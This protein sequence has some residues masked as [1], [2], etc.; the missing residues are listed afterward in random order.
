MHTLIL[1]F[2][3]IKRLS[4]TVQYFRKVLVSVSKPVLTVLLNTIENFSPA[5]A[6][7]GQKRYFLP[8]KFFFLS[9]NAGFLIIKRTSIQPAKLEMTLPKEPAELSIRVN[10]D[11]SQTLAASIKQWV[12]ST[13]QS[14]L[15][16]IAETLNA[17]KYTLLCAT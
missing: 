4:Q 9:R 14:R 16:T 3:Y 15:V 8:S 2:C 7:R 11:Q 1:K 17:R 5:P 10:I 6:K 12:K 13:S